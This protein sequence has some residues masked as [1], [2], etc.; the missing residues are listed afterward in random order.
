MYRTGYDLSDAEIRRRYSQIAE[1]ISMPRYFYR[2]MADIVPQYAGGSR[3]LD[4]GCGNG[5][6][7]AEISRRRPELEL[8]GLEPATALVTGTQS[9]GNGRW[10]IV[11]ASALEVPF[12]SAS[13]DII[14]MTEVLEHMKK[15]VAV[16]RELTRLLKPA[17]RLIIT[18]PN[19]SAYGPFWRLAERIPL[20]PLQRAFL[21]WEHPL[22]TFQPI[23]TAYEFEEIQQIIQDAGLTAE[24]VHGREYLPYLTTSIPIL[25]RLYARF[26]QRPADDALGRVLPARMGYRLVIQC[27]A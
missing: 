4:V 26:A 16:L 21:P 3:L 19:M 27:R 6:L 7:L 20:K 5:Y 1:H 22:K 14:M 18:I 23:D 13:F 25:R 10:H 17:G 15:P 24:E 12:S 8:W 11:A 2:Y 9:R